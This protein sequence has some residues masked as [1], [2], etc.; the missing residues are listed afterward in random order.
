MA[1]RN[2]RRG[3]GATRRLVERKG[4]FWDRFRRSARKIGLRFALR[5]VLLTGAGDKSI[6]DWVIALSD[7]LAALIAKDADK[8][9][10]LTGVSRTQAKIALVET[11]IQKTVINGYFEFLGVMIDTVDKMTDA[12][13]K[14][15]PGIVDT[16]VD[17]P[18]D[19]LRDAIKGVQRVAN[20]QQQQTLESIEA[21][22]RR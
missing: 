22:L 17:F 6:Q 5:G 3:G 19:Q 14:D 11:K 16:I 7:R 15:A 8:R 12:L 1:S 9:P 4:K 13:V 18:E 2:G 20:H 10:R 21:A